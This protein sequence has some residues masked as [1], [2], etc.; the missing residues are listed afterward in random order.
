MNARLDVLAVLANASMLFFA[1]PAWADEVPSA[2]VPVPSAEPEPEP[3]PVQHRWMDRSLYVQAGF[4][5][6]RLPD[7]NR[8]DN[9]ASGDYGLGF[10]LR[11]GF[12][13]TPW[14]AF[15]ANFEW[16]DGMD[17]GGN[18]GDN[19]AT[20]LNARAYPT[21]DLILEGRIQPYLLI[22]LGASSFRSNRSR[23]IGFAM[24]WGGGADFYVTEKIAI[25]IGASYLWSMGTPVK[26]YNYISATAGAM[27]RFY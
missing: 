21:T 11:A 19:W 3:E 24:R 1:V 9:G 10:D 14:I 2:E 15:E 4:S 7:G 12:R 23:E 6:A 20:T 26:D 18:G 13:L 25:T 5:Y 22:G 17:P 27:Y 8:F 16:L